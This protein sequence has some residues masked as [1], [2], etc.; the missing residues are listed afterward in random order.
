MTSISPSTSSD[1]ERPVA[2]FCAEYA[3]DSNL[4]IYA[5]GL[6]ILAGDYIREVNDQG[7]NVVGVGIYYRD[8]NYYR[9]DVVKDAGGSRLLITVPIQDRQVWCQI[10]RVVIGNVPVYL[11]DS[12]VGENIPT[13]RMVTHKLYVSDKEVR[14]KQEIILGIGG[15]RALEAMGIHPMMY[16][17]NEGHSALLTLEL[18]RHEM[19]EKKIGFEEAVKRVRQGV[20]FSNHTLVAAGQEIYSDDLVSLMLAGYATEA[21]LPVSDIVK[22]GQVQET[23]IFSMTMLSLR[24]CERVNAVCKLH[25]QKALEV[26]KGHPMETVTNGIHIPTWDQVKGE[27]LWEAHQRNKQRL[28]DHIVDQAGAKWS[29]D[30]L[31]LGWARR[32]VEYKRPLA[33]FED[34]ER[35]VTMASSADRPVRVV[36]AGEPHESD[37]AGRVMIDRLKEMIKTKLNGLVVYLPGYN[38]EMGKLLTAGCDVWLNTPIVGFEA[39][40]TSGMKAA[41]NGNLPCSTLDGWVAEVEMYK[42]GWLVNSD[43]V[44]QDLLS[45][46]ERDIAP[47][48]YDQREEWKT[49]MG[50]ARQMTLNQFSATR[51]VK[52]YLYK[53]YL[54]KT[55]T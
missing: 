10:M 26:W 29:P 4:P 50:N 49:L 47:L 6:G 34:L 18:V 54:P 15:L 46:L 23:S 14:F 3:L 27:N 22:L 51:M 17:L 36:M 55:T 11:L 2:Y 37:E 20:V 25:A 44:G 41:L 24:M 16:H 5:G 28:L 19:V 45:V 8:Q 43:N 1:S 40:G 9:P 52:D 32:F 31:L 33:L 13:D 48:Y 12:D 21:G 35:F 30:T 38:F 53:L 39:C 42:V 7:L